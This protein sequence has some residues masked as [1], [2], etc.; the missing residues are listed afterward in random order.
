MTQHYYHALEQANKSHWWS[1]AQLVTY[2]EVA[3]YYKGCRNQLK[4]KPFRS[5]GRIF[6][7]TDGSYR[8]THENVDIGKLTSDNVFTFLMDD[9][10]A[11]SCSVTLSQSLY[12]GLPFMWQRARKGKYRVEHTGRVKLKSSNDPRVAWLD[13]DYLRKEAPEYFKGMQ[14]NL[15]TG[16]CINRRPDMVTTIDEDRRKEWLRALRKFKY[17]IKTMA[18]LGAF[19]K[20]I[21]KAKAG[22][23][24]RMIVPDWTGDSALDHLYIAIRDNKCD[25]EL[26]EALA[27]HGNYISYWRSSQSSYQIILNSLENVCNTYSIDLRRKF[28]VF[29][30]ESY[31]CGGEGAQLSQGQEDTSNQGED[32]QKLHG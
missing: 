19:D 2:E 24:G 30:E 29:K 3:K 16:E 14:F 25:G 32:S 7:D 31:V 28:G 27:Q 20:A 9:K 13:W 18:K 23:A 12:R 1:M 21:A 22:S 8:F 10:Q 11:R 15:L 6:L 26:V 4:G 5:W 17:T